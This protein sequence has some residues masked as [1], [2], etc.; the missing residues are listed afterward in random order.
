MI[1]ESITQIIKGAVRVS[2]KDVTVVS[3]QKLATIMMDTLVWKAV[4]GDAQEQVAARFLIWEMAQQVGV[5]PA[6]IHNFYSARGKGVLLADCSVPA[7]NLRGMAYDMGRAV[8]SEAI[9]HQVG[10]FIVEL[11]RSEMGYTD[12]SPE[13]YATVMLAAALREGYRGPV[14]IQ[15]DHFQTKVSDV[16]GKPKDGEVAAVKQLISDAVAAGFYNID[17]DTS[18]LVDLTR[19]TEAAQQLSNIRHSLVFSKHVRTLEPKSVTISL[20]GEI[21]HIGGKN[22]T[23]ADFEAY[24]D[25]FLKRKQSKMVGMSKISVQT[26]TSHGGVVLPDGTL[27]DID[28][29]FKVLKDISDVCRKQYHISGAVQH[30]AS[31]LPD[32][33]FAQFSESGA[34]EVHLATGFQN[35]MMDHPQFPTELREEMYSWLDREKKDER[36]EG[37][38]DDQF[39]YKLRKKAWGQFKKACWGL[40]KERRS[41]I[42]SALAKRFRF[43]FNE[44]KVVNSR[45]IVDKFITPPTI[46]K[47]L[48]DYKGGKKISEIRG[49]AD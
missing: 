48:T 44:L 1:P 46:H 27:A 24:M 25:G 31:T 3:K 29:D 23:V 32:P 12:Q 30:G 18:T 20:G 40:E 13:E 22:S 34:V 45:R 37:W 42:R 7:M 16:A 17:I 38:T 43:M 10:A 5:L 36:K 33:F 11:A 8:F 39:H 41:A 14:F 49:L 6:S 9:R 47:R 35:I 19:E 4:F 21:G 28:V 26:G 15:G 2:D